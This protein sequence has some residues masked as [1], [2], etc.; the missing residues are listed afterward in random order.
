MCITFS[1]TNDGR[2]MD[3]FFFLPILS[4]LSRTRLKK[5]LGHVWFLAIVGL[6]NLFGMA[7]FDHCLIFFIYLF[8]CKV[9]GLLPNVFG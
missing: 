1:A 4:L 7:R 6:A 2:K 8:F 5:N 3:S 9:L